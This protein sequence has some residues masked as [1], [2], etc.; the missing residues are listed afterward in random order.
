MTDFSP[1]EIVS[2]LDRF[3]IGQTDAKR[4]VAVALRNRW[5]RLQLDEKLREEVLPKNIL[6]IG[7]TGVG[8]TEISRRL[9]KLAGAPFLKVEATK[10]TEVGYVGRDVEQIVRDLVEAAIVQTRERRRKDVQARAQLDAEERVVNALV[11]EN[12]SAT[13]KE[14]FR[15]RL[16]AGELNDKEIEIEVQGGGANFPLFD[17]PGMPGAQ[18]GAISIGD[19]LGKLGGGRT[20]KRRVTVAESHDILINEESDKL[21]DNDQ[22]VQEAIQAVEQNGIV[23]LDEIDKIAGREGRVGAD[24][25]REGVQRDLLPLIE[26]TTVSTKHGA[27]KTDHIL[28][29]ASGAFHLSKPSDLLPELQGRLPIRVELR[30]LTRDDFRRILTET[31]ASLIKQYVALLATEGVTLEYTPDAVDAI[32][33]VAVAVNAS[34]ENIGARRLQTVME[35]VLD[36]I[37]FSAPDR[38]GE[39]VQI[40]AA[41]VHAHIGDLAKNADLSRFIL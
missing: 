22:V 19:I 23:F 8:K 40:D 17:I 14:A 5:R 3:I 10:F 6:M 25:S 7:P 31:E 29:I 1:R 21:L 18:M 27:V 4:A 30:A 37:S 35:R 28:F 39:S 34:V 36:E 15:K 33:D 20:K 2:E 11:G 12:A 9:A 13:T 32:A 16:R 26:G 38:S 41:Y 24:V